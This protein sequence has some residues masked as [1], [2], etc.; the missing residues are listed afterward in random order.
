ME[1]CKPNLT[2]A[3]I[4]LLGPSLESPVLK[5]TWEYGSIIGMLMYLANNSRPDIAHAVH[6]CA[7]YTLNPRQHHATAVKHILCYLQGTKNK[8]MI[9]T[10]N[11]TEDSLDCYVDSDF[12]GNYN[13]YNDQDPNS[14]K[15]RTGYVSLY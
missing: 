10:P 8:G 11:L 4:E 6:A 7:R 9:I 3:N 14:T 15:S 13:S 12:A 1:D 2:P 5:E